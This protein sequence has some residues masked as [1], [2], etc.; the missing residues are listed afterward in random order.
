MLL[1]DEVTDVLTTGRLMLDVL[2]TGRTTLELR[3]LLYVDIWE[4]SDELVSDE[5]V[6]VFEPEP[7]GVDDEISL[8][9]D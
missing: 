4:E 3:L 6:L 8:E 1:A 7:V 9:L 2:V 5:L